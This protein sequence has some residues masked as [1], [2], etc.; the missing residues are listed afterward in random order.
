[1]LIHEGYQTLT[2]YFKEFY[3]KYLR[4]LD[5]SCRPELIS[6]NSKFHKS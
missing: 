1:M 6:I 4:Y 3:I 5:M 2:G